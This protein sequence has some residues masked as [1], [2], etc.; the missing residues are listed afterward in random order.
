MGDKVP[1]ATGK[2]SAKIMLWFLEDVSGKPNQ[3]RCSVIA[4]L[5]I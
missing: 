1:G 5:A 3:L 2:P 4:D